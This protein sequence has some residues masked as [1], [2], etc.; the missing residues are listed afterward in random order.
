MAFER[1]FLTAP[2]YCSLGQGQ[3]AAVRGLGVG[4][5]GSVIFGP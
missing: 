2:P 5:G 1:H 4:V 3:P